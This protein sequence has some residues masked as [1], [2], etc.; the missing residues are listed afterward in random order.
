MGQRWG[1]RWGQRC[2]A[3]VG[4]EVWTEGGNSGG[5]KSGDRA[6]G[7]YLDRTGK[8]VGRDNGGRRRGFSQGTAA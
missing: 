6:D 4:T 1:Q 2:G 8:R 5:N 3:V 7:S